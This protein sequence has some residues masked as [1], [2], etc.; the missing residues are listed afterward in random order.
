MLLVSE[1]RREEEARESVDE[2]VCAFV[3]VWCERK[4]HVGLLTF[5]TKTGESFW[6]C[7]A[8]HDTTLEI[9]ARP[10]LWEFPFWVGRLPVKQQSKAKQS[11]QTMTSR[12]SDKQVEEA[13]GMFAHFDKDKDGKLSLE[14]AKEALAALGLT[15]P[16]RYKVIWS[17]PSE[18]ASKHAVA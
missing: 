10:V 11:K 18:Q 14:E 17:Q 15:V 9:T 7:S 16:V 5:M 1:R 13:K 12:L 6:F 2:C 8:L 4:K 3:R